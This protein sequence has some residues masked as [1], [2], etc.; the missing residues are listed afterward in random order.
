MLPKGKRRLVIVLSDNGHGMGRDVLQTD[1]WGLGYSRSRNRNDKIGEKGHGT[2]IYFRSEQ[3]T[4]RTQSA[5]GAYESICDDP[6]DAL[7]SNQLHEPKLRAIDNFLE[8]D[9]TGTEIRIVGYNDNERSKFIQGIVRDYIQ[10]FTK[11]GSIELVFGRKKYENFKVRLKCLNESDFEEITFG[12]RFPDESANIEKLF[13]EKGTAAADW[14]VKRHVVDEGSLTKHPE[15]TY[16]AVISVEGNEAKKQYN[17]MIQ[18][19]SRKET[20]RYRVSDRYGIWLCKDYIPIVR[21]NEWIT[22]FGSGSNALVLLHGFVNCQDLKLTANRG[23]IAN[24]DP[25]ILEELK[26]VVQQLVNYVDTDLYNEGLYTLRSW[27]EEQRTLDQEKAEFKSRIKSLKGRKVAQLEGRL[28]IEPQNESELFGLFVT[29]YALKPDTFEF[30][31]LDYNTNRGLDII[32][33]N[34]SDNQITEGE[35]WYIELKHT[36]QTRFNH[37]YEHLRWIICWDFDKGVA[38]GTE[39]QGVEETDRRRLEVDQDEEDLP[40]YF[41]HNKRKARKIQIVRLKEYLKDRLDIEFHAQA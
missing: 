35:H 23:T 8:A 17:P 41:L 15:V 21:V 27:Q 36:L 14:Y 5:Q 38:Q 19:R 37:A 20:G 29:V 9:K 1:F 2:K 40:V 18:E 28:L 31:P 16:Q 39:F 6:L 24:T 32:A 3:I 4:V 11:I 26:S 25:E 12:H 22:G 30:E 34:K 10:W 7:S 13:E 33:R